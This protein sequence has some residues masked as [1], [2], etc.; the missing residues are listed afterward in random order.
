MAYGRKSVGIPEPDA[1]VCCT[2]SAGEETMLVRRPC[3]SLDCCLMMRELGLSCLIIVY[4]P[5]KKLVIIA[6]RGQLLLIE[7]PLKAADFLL[8][9]NKLC[10]EVVFGPQI[11]MHDAFIT[12]ACT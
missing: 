1:F 4:T 12:R 6:P 10:L 5:E 11:A 3:Y 7:T 9:A 2:T 8:M